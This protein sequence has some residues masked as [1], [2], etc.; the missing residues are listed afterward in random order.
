MKV[1]KISVKDNGVG[2]PEEI[3]KKLFKLYASFEYSK[4]QN[5]HGIY[6]LF[7]KILK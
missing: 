1:I 2:I 6:Y 4:G 7:Y 3:Q 5:K